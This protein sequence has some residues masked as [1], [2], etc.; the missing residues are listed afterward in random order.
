MILASDDF[1]RTDAAT[2][3]GNWTAAV[4]TFGIVSNEAAPKTFE[5]GGNTISG[6][7]AI[8]WPDN[9][10]SQV[11]IRVVGVGTGGPGPAVR[12]AAGAFTA[13][14]AYCSDGAGIIAKWV[15]GVFT[16]IAGGSLLFV[17]GDVAR[18]QAMG[19]QIAL[20]Q[21]DILVASATDAAI[22]SGSAGISSG[23]TDL[24]RRLDDW[25]G[26]GVDSIGSAN[27]SSSAGRYIG[28]IK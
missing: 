11:T 23:N 13:Y 3:G 4:G 25:I 24:T 12:A 10:Y 20:Y 5:V 19:T 9:Q 17:A 1:N 18:L 22:A 27:I 15:A 6:Y 14:V 8:S 28:W 2:L 7:S 16:Q 21:N 26:G